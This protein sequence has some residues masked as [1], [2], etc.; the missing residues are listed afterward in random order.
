MISTSRFS[1][2]TRFF[3]FFIIHYF[4]RPK[5]DENPHKKLCC[6]SFSVPRSAVWTR[7]VGQGE[8]VWARAQAWPSPT[9]SLRRRSSTSPGL[10]PH[11]PSTTSAPSQPSISPES[12]TKP[13]RKGSWKLRDFKECQCLSVNQQKRTS[14]IPSPGPTVLATNLACPDGQPRRPFR[15][16]RPILH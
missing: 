15:S 14:L 7:L 6:H 4:F 10:S 11:T 12:I 2:R 3:L 5:Y 13:V 8:G 1:F 9:R 16:G